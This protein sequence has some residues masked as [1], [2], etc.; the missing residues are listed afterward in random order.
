[1]FEAFP[2][3]VLQSIITGAP[4]QMVPAAPAIWQGI[5]DIKVGVAPALSCSRVLQFASEFLP[6][7]FPGN[8]LDLSQHRVM[9][10]SLDAAVSGVGAVAEDGA[11]GTGF[12]RAAL[13]AGSGH[14]WVGP[15]FLVPPQVRQFLRSPHRRLPG[16]VSS[17][18]MR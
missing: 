17:N 2:L 3:L 7:R 6:A 8:P 16:T 1:M 11:G 15:H 13:R 10:A 5:V 9:P 14:L 4:V 12:T 18:W